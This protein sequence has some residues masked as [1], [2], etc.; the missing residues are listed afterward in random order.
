MSKPQENQQFSSVPADRIHHSPVIVHPQP[1]RGLHQHQDLEISP[2]SRFQPAPRQSLLSIPA[3]SSGGFNISNLQFVG[4][5][6]DVRSSTSSTAQSTTDVTPEESERIRIWR[7]LQSGLDFYDCVCGKRKPQK[8]VKSIL[9]HI[10]RHF[11]STTDKT[12][13]CVKCHREFRHHLG[14]NSHQKIH[15]S[16]PQ[17]IVASSGDSPV[18]APVSNALV[19]ATA[20][21]QSPS[22]A[23]T[24]SEWEVPLAQ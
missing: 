2:T 5:Y 23:S 9:K 17:S 10:V 16:F 24:K 6:N 4:M 3:M 15:K 8:S 13:K 20:P 22:I 7:D 12:Y 21:A 19:I 11:K 1:Q 14:L 18:S